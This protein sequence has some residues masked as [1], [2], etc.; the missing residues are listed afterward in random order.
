M[1]RTLPE[2][3]ALLFAGFLVTAC[4]GGDDSSP[5]GNVGGPIPQPPSSVTDQQRIRATTATA[6]Q[7]NFCT[8]IRPFYGKSV[9]GVRPGV[10]LGRSSAS[11]LTYTAN[12]R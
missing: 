1:N 8:A 3:V 6:Q 2:L 5:R 12:T 11:A 4:G 9:T 10:K 7:N